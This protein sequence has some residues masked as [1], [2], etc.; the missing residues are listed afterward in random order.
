MPRNQD[1]DPSGGERNRFWIL[2]Q[3]GRFWIEEAATMPSLDAKPGERMMV[4]RGSF[5]DRETADK[6]LARLAK[7]PTHQ[8]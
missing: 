4:Q 5:P 2:Q 6:R 3:G 8:S 7:L 1:Q